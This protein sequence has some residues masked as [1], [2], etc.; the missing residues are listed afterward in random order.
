[1]SKMILIYVVCK[2]ETEAKNIA[3]NLLSKKLAACVNTINGMQ[4][5]Y[6]WPPNSGKIEESNETI[7]LIK[8]LKDKYSSI[9]QEVLNLHSYDVPC[10]FSIGIDEVDQKYSRWLEKEIHNK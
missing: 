1:M 4:S 3:K 5:L 2:D 7:L 9:N 10:I 6:I 8:T